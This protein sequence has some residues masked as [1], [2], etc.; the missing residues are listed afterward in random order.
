VIRK[1]HTAMTH[2]CVSQQGNFPAGRKAGLGKKSSRLSPIG[3]RSLFRES[4]KGYGFG[5]FDHTAS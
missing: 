3:N 2:I 4:R 5:R 1:T